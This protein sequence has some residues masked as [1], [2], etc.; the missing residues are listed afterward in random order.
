MYAKWH[1]AGIP[2]QVFWSPLSLSM[3]LISG[4]CFALIYKTL[5]AKHVYLEVVVTLGA[6]GVLCLI[7]VLRHYANKIRLYREG[8][9]YSGAGL[10]F[11]VPYR[12]INGIYSLERS[13]SGH[14]AG[15]ALVLEL[16]DYQIR[17]R[18]ID[19]R[20]FR[21]HAALLATILERVREAQP[22]VEIS[23]ALEPRIRFS[24]VFGSSAPLVDSFKLPGNAPDDTIFEIVLEPADAD[25]S[26]L[27][28]GIKPSELEAHDPH[29]DSHT[30]PYL[31]IKPA[32]GS[33][34]A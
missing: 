10:P 30:W 24:Q 16:A 25:R 23:K 11:W 34:A 31:E 4:S 14:A 21:N 29:L 17:Q 32:D 19:L 28:K 15:F 5:N 7:E 9:L 20:P 26:D 13:S 12:Q 6:M 3:L 2:K 8:I 1:I 22:D 33:S 27:P 18:T